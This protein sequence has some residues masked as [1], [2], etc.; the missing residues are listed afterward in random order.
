MRNFFVSINRTP[1]KRY[2]RRGPVLLENND[3]DAMRRRA[4]TDIRRTGSLRDYG[5][6]GRPVVENRRGQS[7]SELTPRRL[8]ATRE[9]TPA[10]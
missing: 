8:S 10:M 5:A 2:P 3:E 9:H 1:S 7:P 6:G 4:Y